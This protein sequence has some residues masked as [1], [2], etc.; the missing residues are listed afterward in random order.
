M[1]KEQKCRELEKLAF[2]RE[3]RMASEKSSQ[4]GCFSYVGN[5]TRMNSKSKND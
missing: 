3:K 2:E 1:S 4:I 5:F